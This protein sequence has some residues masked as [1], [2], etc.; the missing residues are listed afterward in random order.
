MAINKTINKSTKSHG[1]MRN[2]L[3]YI[4]KKEK[5]SEALSYITGP[6]AYS[7]INYDDVYQSFLQEKRIWGKDTGRMYA[8]NIISWHQD[9]QITLEEA[10][11]FGKE[12]ADKWFVGF[13]TVVTVHRDRDHIH[14]HL[15]TNSVNYEDGHKLHTTKYDL[16]RMKQFTNKMCIDRGLRVAEKGKDFSGKSLDEGHVIAWGKDKYH[17]LQNESK[18]SYVV[19]CAMAVIDAMAQCTSKVNFIKN[20]RNKGWKV[21]WSD[22]RKHITFENEEG[23][24]VRN[25]NLEKTF[26]LQVGKEALLDEFKRQEREYREGEQ[27]T[28]SCESGELARYYNEVESAVRGAINSLTNSNKGEG[29]PATV[30]EPRSEEDTAEF[31]HHIRTQVRDAEVSGQERE[32]EQVTKGKPAE[33]MGRSKKRDCSR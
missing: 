4:L 5:T 20:M 29:K 17:L 32:S 12:F 7:S 30:D 26:H 3:E 31:I 15:V 27:S 8:H 28:E 21:N 14:C 1:A 24:K 6:Y 10:L 16:E 23:K 13:Q 33:Y 11:D 9:E 25:T 19:E 2:C 22:R 18:K